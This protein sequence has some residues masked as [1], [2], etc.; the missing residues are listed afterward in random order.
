[1]KES[2]K[3]RKGPVRL[4]WHDVY[5]GQDQTVAVVDMLADQVDSPGSRTA[6]SWVLLEDRTKH[7]TSFVY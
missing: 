4:N 2:E 7:V 5:H 6:M 3:T 1:M